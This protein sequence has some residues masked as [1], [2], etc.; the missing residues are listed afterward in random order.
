MPRVMARASLLAVDGDLEGIADL[1]N[2]LVAQPADAVHE[3]VRMPNPTRTTV[4]RVLVSCQNAP[5]AQ[6]VVRSRDAR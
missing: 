4:R 1:T 3:Y 2:S 5:T 6:R